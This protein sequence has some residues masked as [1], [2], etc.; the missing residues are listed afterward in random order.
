MSGAPIHAAADRGYAVG[1]QTYVAGR[2]GYPPETAAWLRETIGLGPGRRV[3]E[4]GAGTGKF[5]PHL[6]A[7]GADVTALEPVPAMRAELARL[8]PGVTAIDGTAEHIPLASGSL[9]AVVCA[10]SFHWFANAAALAE[11]RRV[12]R[13]GGV[14]GLIWNVRDERIGWVAALGRIIAPHQGDAPRYYTGEWRRLFPAEA[15]VAL[16]ERH[17]RNDHVGSAEQV[18][19]DRTLSVSFI[20]ALPPDERAR[21]ADQVRA[22]IAATPEL[23]GREQVA[24]PYE[25]AMYAWRKLG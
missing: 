21:V 5:L 16:A 19:L 14:L 17:A 9:D 11:I 25:T 8:N 10:Q 20:A 1:A 6:L 7:T 3:L 23:V 18:I 12:L 2:P 15:F 4:L 24:F 13:P 22:F